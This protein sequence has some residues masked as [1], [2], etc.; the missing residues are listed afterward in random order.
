MSGRMQSIASAVAMVSAAA[1]AAKSWSVP[2]LA[3]MQWGQNQLADL[4]GG[5]VGKQLVAGQVVLLLHGAT[6]DLL[7]AAGHH[8]H[9]GYG[10]AQ[11]VVLHLQISDGPASH[12]VASRCTIIASWVQCM[13][14]QN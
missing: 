3:G 13:S 9:R 8:R 14:L 10:C 5:G 6:E 12:I 11:N 7:H 2:Y 4:C 1:D